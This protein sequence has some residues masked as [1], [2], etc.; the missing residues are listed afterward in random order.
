MLVLASFLLFSHIPALA[1]SNQAAPVTE[2][3]TQ[4]ETENE[5]IAKVL[6]ELS[7]ISQASYLILWPFVALAGLAMDNNLVY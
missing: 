5:L 6:G 2:T 1:T 4:V 3:K 7:F